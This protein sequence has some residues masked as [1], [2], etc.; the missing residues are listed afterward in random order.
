MTASVVADTD[1]LAPYRELHDHIA[2]HEAEY[3]E[4]VRRYLRIRSFSDTGEGMADGAAATL[5]Y[6]RRIGAEDACLV[7]TGGNPVVYGTIRSKRPDAKT[8][9]IYGLY[10]HPPSI[11]EEWLVDPHGAEIVDAATIGLPAD[12]GSVIPN[13]AAHNHKGP[14]LSCL[15]AV[16][17][18][19]KVSGDVPV[20]LL[21]VIEGEEDIGSPHLPAFIREYRDELAQAQ[22]MWLPC[23][24]QSR[25]GTMTLVRGA[26]GMFW[27]ELVCRGGAWGGAAD[28]HHLWAGH[29]PWI[30]APMMRLLHAVGS[31]YDADHHCIIDGLAAITPTVSAADRAEIEATKA[32]IAAHPEIERNMRQLLHVERMRGGKPLQ[33]LIERWMLGVNLN[34][35]GITGGY[36]GPS[37]YSMLPGAARAKVD[38]RLPPSI[39]PEQL[40]DLLRAH[41]DRRGFTEIE[42]ANTRGYPAAQPDLNDLL[43]VAAARAA[44]LHGVP[45]VVRTLSNSIWPASLFEQ[46]GIPSSSAGIG[47]GERPHAPHE[48]I[49]TDAVRK[50][51]QFTVTYLHEWSNLP[52]G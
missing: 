33:D 2:L 29:S 19:R 44:T 8:L 41:L 6:L 14:V 43:L 32:N 21:F 20:N 24:Q 50:L 12:L 25:D 9:I 45:Y 3:V 35:Q 51:M 34:V 10:D 47:H 26:K 13:R 39:L 1:L 42:I 7:P 15:L 30:D 23:M 49:R 16:E 22:G 52:R 40:H 28:G 31:L 27:A 48:Y 38:F 18:M 37:F 36:M 17:V 11:A 4:E 46:L 5:A